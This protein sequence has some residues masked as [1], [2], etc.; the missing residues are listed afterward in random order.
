ML[1]LP[2]RLILIVPDAIQLL[3]LHNRE[4]QDELK[5]HDDPFERHGG[6]D[7]FCN[8]PISHDE[9]LEKLL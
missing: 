6:L 8:D 4:Q 2:G 3:A 9:A 1:K 7:P 5:E